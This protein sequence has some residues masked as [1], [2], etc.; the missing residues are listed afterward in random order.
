MEYNAISFFSGAM[1]LDIGIE[2]AGFDIRVCV[3]NDKYCCET[4]KL[5]RPKIPVLQSRIENLTTE[6][7]LAVAGVKKGDVFLVHGGPPCQAFSTAG[8]RKSLQ[9]IRGNCIL[10]F[11]KKGSEISPQYFIMENVRGLL[12]AAVSP[13]EKGRRVTSFEERPG[14]ALQYVLGL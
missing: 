1:G 8:S 9:D 2:K 11:I 14:S 6:E 7:I 4:I 12:S 13:V 10:E 3:D 5:N